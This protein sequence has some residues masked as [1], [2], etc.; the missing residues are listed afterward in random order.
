MFRKNCLKVG[1]NWF[2]VSKQ[3]VECIWFSSWI[4]KSENLLW[5]FSHGKFNEFYTFGI[6]FLWDFVWVV[7]LD[8]Y[9]IS[10]RR[11]DMCDDEQL[12]AK[13]VLILWDLERKGGKL[14][15]W[16]NV[17]SIFPNVLSLELLLHWF[18]EFY[19]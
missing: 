5:K 11:V 12:L 8:V 9:P 4:L 19:I 2:F 10:S 6:K 3:K 16:I 1:R 7:F 14:F 18:S 17:A 15:F 13:D